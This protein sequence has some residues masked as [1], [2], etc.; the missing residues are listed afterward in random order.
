M[1]KVIGN[2]NKI[3]LVETIITTLLILFLIVL[4][5]YRTVK[6]EN[7]IAMMMVFIGLSIACLYWLYVELRNIYKYIKTPKNI[8]E[9]DEEFIYIYEFKNFSKIKINQIKE[10]KVVGVVN[11]I[12]AHEATL[13]IKDEENEF[14]FK[15]IKK[16]EEVKS[17]LEELINGI[18]IH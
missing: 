13:Y 9:A 5:I 3:Y 18:L 12:F 6:N 14:Y 1:K 16:P 10:V 15:L 4:C 8:I 11:K 7:G 17:K 2:K